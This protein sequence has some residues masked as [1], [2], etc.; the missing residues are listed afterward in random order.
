[1]S[2]GP[3]AHLVAP[4]AP[5]TPGLHGVGGRACSTAL[6]VLAQREGSADSPGLDRGREAKRGRR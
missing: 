5:L 2:A 1:M 3:T 4:A 6:M